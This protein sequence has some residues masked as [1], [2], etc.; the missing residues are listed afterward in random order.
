MIDFEKSVVCVTPCGKVRG[1]LLEGSGGGLVGGAGG[2]ADA[3]CAGG[4]AELASGVAAGT[5]IFQGIPYAITERFEMPVQVRSWKDV[6][7]FD[8]SSSFEELDCW[9]YS[10][11]YDESKDSNSFYYKEFRSDRQFKYAESPMT[12]NIVCPWDGGQEISGLEET[13]WE[14]AGESSSAP[15]R[16]VVMF[17]HGGGHETGTVGELPYG[18]CTEYAKRGVIFVSVGYRLNVFSLFRGKNYGL[19]DQIT[20]IH[21]VR[22][23]IAAFG[24]NPEQIILMGQSAG[25]MSITDL[26]YSQKLKGLVKGAVLMSGGGCIPKLA[27]PW[28]KE[29]CDAFWDGVRA[30]AGVLARKNAT[31]GSGA[32]SEA[33]A[34]AGVLAK[35]NATAGSG[36]SSE[37]GATAG[38]LAKK[39]ATAGSGASSEA[40]ATAGVLAKK[41]ATAGSGAS[42]EAG[43]TAGVTSD[44]DL[45]AV[46]AEVLWRA[47]YA[48]TQEGTNYHLRQPAIDGDIIPDYPQEILRRGDELDIPLIFGVTAQDFLPVIMYEMALSWGKRNAKK[49]R[50]P[51]YGY[52]VRRTPPGNSYKAFHGIDLWYMFG[53]LNKSWRPFTKEDYA[54]SARMID[55]IATF[56]RTGNPN[57]PGLP[58]WP[59]ISKDCHKFMCFDVEAEGAGGSSVDSAGVG[60]VGDGAGVDP[61]GIGVPSSSGV[62]TGVAGVAE[63]LTPHQC[64]KLVWHTALKDKGPL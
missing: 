15:G 55:H 60:S 8:D 10:A 12:L 3:G 59:A 46:S 11:F 51:V 9:Q 38:V 31:A 19:H 1:K 18:T 24:G 47:W 7:G 17:F 61:V 49:G 40:G 28:P 39:N 26:C 52:M 63:L 4:V 32:S 25:A 64:R 33:G 29:K 58:Q 41:N 20:A 50:C 48:Q 6:P 36:A 2:A 56:A 54:L 43:A 13:G 62:G 14:T 57:A 45:K 21:W 27:G 30:K 16:P 5:A 42:S 35:K 34:T 23:N 53:N 44:E 22:D 37:A